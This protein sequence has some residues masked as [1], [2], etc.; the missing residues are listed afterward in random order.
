MRLHLRLVVLA[1]ENLARTLL[2][3]GDFV[4]AEALYAKAVED[5]RKTGRTRAEA[6]AVMAHAEALS[7]MGR[8]EAAKAEMA[9]AK[10]LIGVLE[11]DAAI[12]PERHFRIVVAGDAA[13]RGR[14]DLALATVHGLDLPADSPASRLEMLA[15]QCET[16]SKA[17]K[18]SLAREV[19][20]QF[21]GASESGGSRRNLLKGRIIEAEVLAASGDPAS[22]LKQASEIMAEVRFDDAPFI[23]LLAQLIHLQTVPEPGSRPDVSRT[24]A[25]LRLKLGEQQFLDWSRRADVVGRM[26]TTARK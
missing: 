8:F 7:V 2:E 15:I 12:A 13:R 22:A 19:C 18:F 11:R 20:A 1:S 17:G 14:Y 21:K 26:R 5:T 10:R 9:E 16:A 23:Y 25:A 24:L 6:Y 3:T 4:E